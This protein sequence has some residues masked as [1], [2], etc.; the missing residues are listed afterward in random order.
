M[1]NSQE[2]AIV[3]KPLIKTGYEWLDEMKDVRNVQSSYKPSQSPL[4]N[5]ATFIINALNTIGVQYELDIFDE[6]GYDLY[7][8]SRPKILNIIV[9]FGSRSGQ[10]AIAFM[11]HHDVANINSENC[12]DNSA[13]VCNLL[14]LCAILKEQAIGESKNIISQRPVIIVFSDKEEVGGTGSRYFSGRMLRGDFGTIE[15]VLNLELTGLGD[16]K[17]IWV[18]TENIKRWKKDILVKTPAILKCDEILGVGGYQEVYTPFSDSF[19]MRRCGVDSVCIGILP[20][21]ELIGIGRKETW[22]LCHSE[23]DTIEKCNEQDMRM[24][25]DILERFVTGIPI[26]SVT[27][28]GQY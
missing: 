25:V 3:E 6:A 18:D 17:G 7:D 8:Y 24:F 5:R 9:R 16:R 1:S 4:T 20:A 11:A 23:T 22:S 13:S 10:P 14:H 12:Q 15:Y 19:V 21:D 27:E 2:I 28:V 26:E